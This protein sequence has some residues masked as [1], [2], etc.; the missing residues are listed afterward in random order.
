VLQLDYQ[1]LKGGISGLGSKTKSFDS[2]EHWITGQQLTKQPTLLLVALVMQKPS[3]LPE[4][5][6]GSLSPTMDNYTP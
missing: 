4:P 2:N 6:G 1:S 5:A 3:E